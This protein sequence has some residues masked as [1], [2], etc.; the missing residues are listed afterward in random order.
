MQLP[1]KARRCTTCCRAEPVDPSKT[2]LRLMPGVA[3]GTGAHATTRL[4][5]TWLQAADLTNARVV[6]YGCGSGI[7]AVAACLYGAASV[8]R[9][10]CAVLAVLRL[11]TVLDLQ[12][13]AAQRHGMQSGASHKL[14]ACLRPYI[15]W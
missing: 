5:A 3:F 13:S 8:V 7:L 1:H 9:S 6:D 2:N 15:R 10:A 11:L 4:C 14:T 12:R